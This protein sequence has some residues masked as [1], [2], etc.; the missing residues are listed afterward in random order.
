MINELDADTPSTDISEFIELFDG[1]TGYTSLTGLVLVFYNGA[2]DA[3]YR[4]IDL[5]GYR[6]N[7]GGYLLVANPEVSKEAVP[8]PENTLQN[9]ADAVALYQADDREFPNGTPVTTNHLIDAIVY[10]TTDADDPGLLILVN[11]NQPQVDENM[12]GIGDQESIQR[13]PNG[14]GL[15]RNTVTYVVTLPTPGLPNCLLIRKQAPALVQPGQ[16]F[17]YTITVDNFLGYPVTGLVITDVLP[18]NTT[19][20]EA[21][22]GGNYAEGIVSWN[23]PFLTDRSRA[24]VRYQVYASESPGVEII[25]TDYAVHATNFITPT[26]G[27]P[28]ITAVDGR[29]EFIHTIQ[30]AGHLSPLQGEFVERVFGIVTAVRADGFYMQDPVPDSDPATSEGIYVDTGINPPVSVGDALLVKGKVQEYRLDGINSPSLTIT[31]LISPTILSI[32]TANPLPEPVTLGVG[33]RIPPGEVIE[34]DALGDV[35]I[36]GVFDPDLDGIDFYESLEVM[37]VQIR[38]AVS[39]GPTDAEG[40]IPILLDRGINASLR[41]LRGGIIIG[42]HDFNPERILVDDVILT[43]EP[44][45]S[46]GTIFSG[47]ILGV[48]DYEAG[49]FRLLNVSSFSPPIGGVIS[50]TTTLVRNA[51]QLMIATLNLENLAPTDG[52]SKFDRLAKE[53]VLN[54]ESPDLIAVEEVQDNTGSV[55]DGVVDAALTI[56]KL[57]QAIQSAGGPTYS[58]RQIDS[59]N[60]QDGGDP[61]GNIRQVFLFRTDRGLGFVDRPG[62]TAITAISVSQGLEGVHLS[63]S[64]GRIDP[65]NNAFLSSRK[66]LV[67]EFLFQGNHLFVIANHFNSKQGD[68]PLFGRYQPPLFSTEARRNQQAQI[69]NNFVDQILAIDPLARVIV[70]G[71]LNDYTFSTPLQTLEGGVLTNLVTSLPVE[72]QYTYLFEGNSQAIDHILVS[73]G[74]LLSG[75]PGVDIVHMNAEFLENQRPTDHDPILASLILPARNP[76]YLPI[77]FR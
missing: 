50:E 39:V 24:N 56:N 47:T 21:L 63:F 30:G 41:S 14:S 74:V 3:S 69:V 57:I 73:V 16:L 72:D 76:V 33:G 13:C 5:D 12:H 48:M 6:T 55:N 65:G 31:E 66:P 68:Q 54:L 20:V 46:V 43:V 60:N 36:S 71:D 32:S 44:K 28:V 42:D 19:F 59:L 51:N 35:E 49:N 64:P 70:M 25:N 52:Q 18:L 58:Y 10:D 37:L 9:G 8:F 77:L 2:N 7:A 45:V 11:P 17:T 1:G 38:D 4:A 22:D 29:R 15:E 26:F 34:D 27:V 23:L 75:F 67:G 61:G 62:G 40:R 53:I